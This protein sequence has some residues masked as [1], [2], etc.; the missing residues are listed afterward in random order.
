MAGHIA[1]RYF[2]FRDELSTD[3]LLKG[4]RL[5][6][7]NMLQD[8]YLHLLHEGHS[9]AHNIQENAKEHLYW[10]FNTNIVDFGKQCQK[11]IKRSRQPKEPLQPHD[12]PERSSRTIGMDLLYFNGFSYFLIADY[13]SKFPH[14]FKAKTSFWSLRDHLTNLF[15]IEGYTDKIFYRQWSPIQQHGLQQIFLQVGY[16]TYHLITPLSPEQWLCGENGTDTML[17]KSTETQSFQEVL[18]NLRATHMGMGLPSPSEILHI[19]MTLEGAMTSKL[20][21]WVPF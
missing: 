19:F 14:M 11:Y 13:F 4:P 18:A 3:N 20:K 1:R 7:P 6:I 16:H 5:V 12:I 10:H 21:P 15:A 9:S 17:S 8:E 2:D